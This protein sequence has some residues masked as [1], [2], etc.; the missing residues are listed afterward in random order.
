MYVR[1]CK[2][3][4]IW[5]NMHSLHKYQICQH[6]SL[7]IVLYG[8]SIHTHVCTVHR[9]MHACMHVVIHM[10]MHMIYDS[11]LG[12]QEDAIICGHRVS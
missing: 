8:R 11:E 3:D 9:Y 1:M 5:E 7:K 10:Y 4:W 12:A 6:F 2:C